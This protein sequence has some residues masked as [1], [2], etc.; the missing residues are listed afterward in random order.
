MCNKIGRND[1]CSCGSRKKF[2]KCCIDRLHNIDDIEV[3][4]PNNFQENYR[5][6]KGDSRIKR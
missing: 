6:I 4:N 3:S 1:L 2:K 5:E